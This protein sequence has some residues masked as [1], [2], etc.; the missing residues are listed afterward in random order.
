MKKLYLSWNKPYTLRQFIDQ[1]NKCECLGVKEVKIVAPEK[2][3][4]YP[5]I[6]VPLTVL[7]EEYIER[8]TIKSQALK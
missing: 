1:M 5:D 4:T 8:L 6:C 7:I 2:M 3:K